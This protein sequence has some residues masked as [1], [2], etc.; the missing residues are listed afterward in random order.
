MTLHSS[1]AQLTFA[2]KFLIALKALLIGF[3][4]TFFGITLWTLDFTYIP[5]PW[6][7]PLIAF[8]FMVIS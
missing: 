5:M 1:A 7:L 8:D 4:V 3:I 2:S 6:S